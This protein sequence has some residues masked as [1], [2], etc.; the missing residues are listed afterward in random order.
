MRTICLA[1]TAGL[2]T[3]G[4]V[5]SGQSGQQ[6]RGLEWTATSID[7]RPVVAGS[8]AVTLRLKANRRAGGNAH[9]N[10]WHGNYRLGAGTISFSE[11]GSTRRYCP[12]PLISQETQYLRIIGE[13]DRYNSWA[14]GTMTIASPQGQTV[15]FRPTGVRTN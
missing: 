4:C 8:Q 7:G 11:I 13:A 9:C 3:G 5:G 1:A 12:E 14:D 15:T 10:I 2:L 6:I